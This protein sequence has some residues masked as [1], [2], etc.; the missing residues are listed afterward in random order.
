MLPRTLHLSL[1]LK[2][3]IATLT[4]LTIILYILLF[5]ISP[6]LLFFVIIFNIG[7]SFSFLYSDHQRNITAIREN[8]ARMEEEA[9][10]GGLAKQG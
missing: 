3:V 5:K 4:I 8:A 9:E 1:F 7:A 6:W 2:F 10:Y